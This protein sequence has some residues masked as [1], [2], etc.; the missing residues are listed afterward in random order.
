MDH[1]AARNVIEA[2]T[3]AK[4]HWNEVNAYEPRHAVASAYP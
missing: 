1:L 2:D 3:V 4:Q